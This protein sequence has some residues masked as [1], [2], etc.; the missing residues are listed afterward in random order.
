M[1]TH[2]GVARPG[3]HHPAGRS[4]RLLLAASAVIAAA[5]AAAAALDAPAGLL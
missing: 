3:T 1:A 2:A 5:A 4:A